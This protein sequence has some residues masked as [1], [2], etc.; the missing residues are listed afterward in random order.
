MRT[1]PLAEKP[2]FCYNMSLGEKESASLKNRV[3]LR[4][5]H[6]SVRQILPSF[7][8]F[9]VLAVFAGEPPPFVPGILPNAP[10]KGIRVRALAS[11]RRAFRGFP[12]SRTAPIRSTAA[13]IFRPPRRGVSSRQTSSTPHPPTSSAS[14]S[15]SSPVPHSP[16]PVPRSQDPLIMH[17]GLCYN[18]TAPRKQEGGNA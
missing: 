6:N 1:G 16:F 11:A 3:A 8:V 15:A 10:G 18:Q 4:H 7:V 17:E 12:I 9:A 13:T 5:C 2:M 14:P